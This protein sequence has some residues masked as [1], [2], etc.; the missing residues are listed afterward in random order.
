MPDS[1]RKLNGAETASGRLYYG[2]IIVAVSFAALIVVFGIR[3]SFAVFFVELVEE[4][5]WP[6][7][8]TSLI[9]STTMITFALTSTLA[10]ISL[11]RFGV[12]V[13][14]GTGT[15]VLALGLYLSSRINSF[16]E[17][18]LTYGVIAGLGITIL[19]LALQASLIS[20]WF[21]KRR[22]M[23]IGIAFAGTGIGTLLI[24]PAVEWTIR[25]YDWRTAYVGLAVLAAA[26]FPAVTLLLRS[27]PEDKGLQIDGLRP[28][29][30][31]IR[32]ERPVPDEKNWTF[33][34]ALRTP[35]FW[36]IMLAGFTAIGPVRMLTVHQMAVITD[37]GISRATAASFIGAAGMV[38]ALVF[39]LAGALSDRIG[40]RMTYLLGSFCLAGAMLLLNSLHDPGQLSWLTLYVVLL[41]MGEGSRAS[42]ITAVAADLFP[43][44]ALGA[45]NGTT[46]AMFGLGAAILPWLAGYI[47]DIQGAYSQAF[48]IAIAW[49]VISSFALWSAPNWLRRK[50]KKPGV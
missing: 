37:A 20:N 28:S 11:D 18:V 46:G 24:T 47:F 23:A 43:G 45:I 9:F 12:R 21:K 44:T 14:F 15:L 26:G 32:L 8:N 16:W 38:T 29:N 49:T 17:L 42:L 10:G 5:D 13:T 41:G 30:S 35:S 3:L 2:W 19:G 4:F 40:R 36:L 25:S 7:A 50:I 33:R 48:Y 1:S 31:E 6:R 22:G 27:K 34:E 39:I